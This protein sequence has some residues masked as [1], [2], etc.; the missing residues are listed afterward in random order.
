MSPHLL[1]LERV[2]FNVTADPRLRKAKM[3][4]TAVLQL[5]GELRQRE[6]E[7]AE[8]RERLRKYEA[9]ETAA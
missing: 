8:L 9:A 3:P 1:A 2:V 5:F 6:L 7:V 4:Y